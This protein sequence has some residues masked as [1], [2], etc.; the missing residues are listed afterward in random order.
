MSRIQDEPDLGTVESSETTAG[1]EEIESV[2][3]GLSLEQVTLVAG[4]RTLLRDVTVDLPAGGI[5]LIVGVS[6]S[7]KS[8][9]LR[10]LAGLPSAFVEQDGA[11]V[12]NVAASAPK[13]L[14]PR[15]VRERSEAPGELPETPGSC[16]KLLE[17]P[18]SP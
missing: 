2:G 4:R 6:G 14:I 18:A 8:Q 10:A 13:P 3:A 15:I 9:L 17:A 11:L 7:G 1:G 12:A 16:Q 5:V